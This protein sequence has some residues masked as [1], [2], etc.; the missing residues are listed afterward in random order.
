MILKLK[1]TPALYLIGFMACGKTTVG[2]QLAHELGWC[3]I[4]IDGEIEAQ[5]GKTVAEMFR[6]D[7]EPAFR[8]VEK[9]MVRERVS[10]VEC[11]LPCVIAVGGGA[12][13]DPENWEL[14]E[15]NGVTVWLDCPLERIRLRLRGDT[16]RPLA[17]RSDRLADLFENRRPLYTRSDFRVDADTDDVS[18]VVQ[19][20]LQLPIF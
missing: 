15:N 9:Q 7:G 8:K 6:E 2:R 19:Q 14:I 5:H 18:A 20:I 13:V 10:Q 12:I 17:A 16:T 4:D 1:R 3:F 11:G